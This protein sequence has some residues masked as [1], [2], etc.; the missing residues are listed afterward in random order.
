MFS[1]SLQSLAL[2][3]GLGLAALPAGA[4]DLDFG[5]MSP[6]E[7]DAFGKEVRSYILENPEII[8]EAIQI[9][10]ARRN[11]AAQQADASLI[12]ANRGALLEDGFS[13]VMGNPEGD[14]TVV[15]FIDYRCGFCK[16]AHP[17]VLRLVE[18]DPNVRLILKEFPILGPDSIAAGRMAVAAQQID[19]ALYPELNDELMRF[20]GQLNETM[21]YR[22]ASQVGYDIGEL[23][24]LAQSDEIQEKISRTYA[25]ASALRIEG[26][27]SFVIG[28]QIARGFVPF[29]DM[30][31]LV[32][33]E[34]N[35]SN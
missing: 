9:L 11:E 23:K 29:D 20:Q 25:L 5:S 6:A 30:A 3:A 26:T 12:A 15:E 34:R 4:Q 27:P 28:N 24:E 22:I 8:F 1:R 16:R 31:R 18:S 32:E 7:R 10:E 13:H 33:E 2:A 14:V 19:P 35:A 21:A 17:E